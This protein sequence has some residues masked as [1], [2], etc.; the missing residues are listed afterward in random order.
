M[1]MG[2]RSAAPRRAAAFLRVLLATS[3]S[4]L[5]GYSLTALLVLTGIIAAP[6]NA[7]GYIRAG[8]AFWGNLLFWLVGRRV[9][10]SGRENIAPGRAYLVLANHSSMYDIPALLAVIPDLALV[11]REKL[12]HIPVFRRLLTIIRYVPIDTEKIR[13]AREAI[14]EAVRRA[15]DGCSIGMF[16]EGTRTPDGRVQKLK[17][18]FVYVLRGSGLDALPVTISG[19]FALKPKG[20]LTMDPREKIQVTVHPPVPNAEL[21][22]LSDEQ[23]MEEI[24]S[25]LDGG[26]NGRQ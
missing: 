20:R 23:I 1:R 13:K 10:V 5:L 26:L 18:G 17:R 11:G 8:L 19:T 7:R 24:R 25:L 22:P 16:P 21:V 9:H 3:S 6:L 14:A 15:G 4:Y 2:P 12:M